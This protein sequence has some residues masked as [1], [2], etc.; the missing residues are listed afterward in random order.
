M[1]NADGPLHQILR[2]AARAE[3][4]LGL[5]GC[6]RWHRISGELAFLVVL[7]GLVG[8]ALAGGVVAAWSRRPWIRAA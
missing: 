2:W 1:W 3:R 5:T 8:V 6:I 4:K 7:F